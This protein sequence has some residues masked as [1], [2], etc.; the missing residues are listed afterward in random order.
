MAEGNQHP[1]LEL[2]PSGDLFPPL[3]ADPH[4]PIP[5]LKYFSTTNHES[6]IGKIAA[7]AAFGLIRLEI[8]HA[9]VQ[10]NIE[11]GIF[12]RFDLNTS[13]IAETVDYRLGLSLNIARPSSSK[14][15]ALQVSPYHTS[16][17][18]VDDYIFKD[19]ETGQVNIPPNYSREVVRLLAA[20][21][22]SPLN[23]IYA[24]M[25]YAYDG[26]NVRALLNYQA[27]SEF[28]TPAFLLLGREFRLY[29][30]EDL[31]V[32]EEADWNLNL[33]L[34]AGLSIKSM[35]DR[36]G[37]RIAVEYFAGNAVEGQFSQQKEQNVGVA[38][39]FEL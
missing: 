26:I 29:L 27:G 2:V 3:L 19:S 25:A 36:H 31:Q 6:F 5:S 30:A 13:V 35:E 21:R 22:F 37:L 10:L 34:Q 14:G 15:W 11:G 18:L 4:T 1:V 28:F 16:A 32:K 20:Y 17:H 8:P 39:I 33:N 38:A 23:R 7:G 12:S 24:G 9:A